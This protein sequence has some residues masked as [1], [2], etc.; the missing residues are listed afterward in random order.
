M[1]FGLFTVWFYSR[2][3]LSRFSK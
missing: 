3:Y 1:N 2:S